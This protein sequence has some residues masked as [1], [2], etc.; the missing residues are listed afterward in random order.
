M[1][2]EGWKF[3]FP[4]LSSLTLKRQGPCYQKAGMKILAPF[5]VFPE[6]IPARVLSHFVTSLQ[7][8]SPLSHYGKHEVEARVFSCGI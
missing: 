3:R 8:C 5:F 4:M 6:K 7:R 2:R 1:A